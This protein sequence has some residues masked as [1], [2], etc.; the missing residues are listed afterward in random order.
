VQEFAPFFQGIVPDSCDGGAELIDLS[1][2]GYHTLRPSGARLFYPSMVETA[3]GIERY[4]AFARLAPGD[5]VLDLGAYAGDSTWFFSRAV[6][7]QGRVLAVEPD[8]E[9]LAALRRNIQENRLANVSV[10]GCAVLDRDGWVQFR[11]A[12]SIG[13]GIAEASERPDPEIRVPALSLET[14]LERHGFE[15][16]DFIKMDIEGAE[17]KALAGQGDLLRRLRPRMVIEAHS[18]HGVSSAP[19]LAELLRSWGCTVEQDRVLLCAAW[20]SRP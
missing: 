5:H 15:R 13:S 11:A 2:P 17:E 10:E 19:R 1:V 8:P 16:V 3:E 7:P 9:N 20:E 4:L 12:G 14:L 18:P 6:G